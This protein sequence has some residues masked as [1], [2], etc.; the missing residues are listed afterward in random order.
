M[1]VSHQNQRVQKVA[2]FVHS[3]LREKHAEQI[4]K[5]SESMPEGYGSNYRWEHTLRV[6]QYGK[7]IALAEGA[8]LE[9]VIVACLLHD[10]SHFEIEGNY[11]DHGRVSSKIARTFLTSLDYSPEEIANICYSV[12]VH[13]DGKADFDHPETLE[14]KCVSDADNIDRF[15][16]LR[17]VKRISEDL[18]DYER[19]IE[20][21]KD[22]IKRY[23]KYIDD[24]VLET[25]TG[26]IFFRIQLERFIKFWKELIEE[27]HLT[28]LAKLE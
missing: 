4:E 18:N 12:A 14:A 6:A 8:D 13:V 26:N 11:K 23:Q 15:G 5:D 19:L 2:D 7:Q 16:V 9:L 21:G 28:K 3:Y 20:T 1:D 22:A 17:I 24:R 10:V 25:N 27:S